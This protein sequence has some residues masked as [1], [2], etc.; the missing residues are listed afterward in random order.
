MDCLVFVRDFTWIIFF[1]PH[2]YPVCRGFFPH[3]V[4]EEAEAE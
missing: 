2:S 3:V 4:A 1:N